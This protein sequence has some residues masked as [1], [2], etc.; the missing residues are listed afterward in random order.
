MRIQM[1]T[2]SFESQS[3]P[4]SGRWDNSTGPIQKSD[5][6]LGKRP[7]NILVVDDDTDFHL[8]IKFTFSGL[9]EVYGAQTVDEALCFLDRARI[10]L[11]LLDIN[12]PGRMGWDFLRAVRERTSAPPVI[13]VTQDDRSAVKK[14]AEQLG[15]L[16]T[17]FKPVVPTLLRRSGLSLL[18]KS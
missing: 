13:V 2:G 7:C 10:D 1:M 4:G 6:G 9:H 14:Q 15:A 8:L 12:L 18:D 3:V 5:T 11:V 17:F 16:D